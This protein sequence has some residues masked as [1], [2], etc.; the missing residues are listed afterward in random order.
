MDDGKLEAFNND[1]GGVRRTGLDTLSATPNSD[2]S[3]ARLSELKSVQEKLLAVM[4]QKSGFILAQLEAEGAE[5]RPLSPYAQLPASTW[6]PAGA[7]RRNGCA[8]GA[9]A[10]RA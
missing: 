8:P 4:G 2:V 3:C 10:W 5:E 1:I 9:G 6:S 7:A